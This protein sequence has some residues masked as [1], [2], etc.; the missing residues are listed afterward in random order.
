MDLL[1]GKGVYVCLVSGEIWQEKEL[2][3]EIVFS[4]TKQILKMNDQDIYTRQNN[5]YSKPSFK[6]AQ[7]WKYMKCFLG[8]VKNWGKK[9]KYS[10]NLVEPNKH[11]NYTILKNTKIITKNYNTIIAIGQLTDG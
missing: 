1:K 9:I 2:G 10:I 11:P 8:K 7:A 6:Q 5:Y 4:C 3:H